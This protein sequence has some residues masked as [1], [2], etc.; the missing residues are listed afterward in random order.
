L[1]MGSCELFAWAGLET[2][3][4]A[5]QVTRITGASHQC[6]VTLLPLFSSYFNSPLAWVKTSRCDCVL[7]QNRHQR[8]DNCYYYLYLSTPYWDQKVCWKHHM[9]IDGL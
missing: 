5:S 7:V 8:I 2:Q 3:S 9:W 4:S 6:L 1:E